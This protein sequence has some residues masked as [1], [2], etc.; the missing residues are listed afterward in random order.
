M[1]FL[2]DLLTPMLR[3]LLRYNIYMCSW[4]LISFPQTPDLTARSFLLVSVL[5][6]LLQFNDGE[7]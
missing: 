5:G 2:K 4:S 1:P 7:I 6:F 3:C